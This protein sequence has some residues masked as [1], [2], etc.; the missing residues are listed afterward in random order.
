MFDGFELTRC[1]GEGVRLRVRYGGR[2]PAV[3]LLHG[4]PRTHATWHRVAP[5][6]AAAG[7]TVV[8]P[9]LRGYGESD[10]PPT[11]ERHSPYSKRA[12]AGDCL[13][14]MRRLGHERFAVVGHDRGAYVATRLALD[15]PEAVSALSVLDAV[16]LGEALRRCDAT[17]AASWWHWFFL[18]Q[19]E[20]PAERLINADPDAWYRATPEQMGAEAYEDYRRAIH[21]PATV[22]AMCEDYRAGLGVDREHDDADRHAGRRV[23]CRLQVLWATDDDMADLYGDVLSVWRDW[24]VDRPTGGP[25]ASGHHIAEEAPE[26]LVTALREFWRST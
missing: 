6:L 25:I 26:A 20:K 16:P 13:A 10:K 3:L 15:H 7:H 18:G 21:D 9:D 2:G 19:T 23:T 17:F 8:C 1:E 14:V 12:M 22:H 5:L 24:A 11:D 4:H